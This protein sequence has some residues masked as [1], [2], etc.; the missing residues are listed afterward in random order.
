MEMTDIESKVWFCLKG[1]V[2]RLSAMNNN[3]KGSCSCFCKIPVD[4]TQNAI[5]APD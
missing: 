5:N 1:L 2:R 4:L 3:V